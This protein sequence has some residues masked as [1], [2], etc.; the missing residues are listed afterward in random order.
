MSSKKLNAFAVKRMWTTV[1][2]NDLLFFG[3]WKEVDPNTL[4]CVSADTNFQVLT[5]CNFLSVIDDS[6]D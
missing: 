1:P 5:H 6:S 2:N 4:T 3:I